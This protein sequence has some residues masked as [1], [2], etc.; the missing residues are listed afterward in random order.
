M[1]TKDSI[2]VPK[3]SVKWIALICVAFAV[4][5][6]VGGSFSIVPKG[7]EQPTAPSAPTQPQAPQQPS[8]VKF[9][10]PSYAPF[11]G[12]SSA[13]I[14]FIENGSATVCRTGSIVEMSVASFNSSDNM[15]GF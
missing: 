15:I 1:P 3:S 7:A 8:I 13:K 2:S 12:S 11:K 6:L 9:D 14:S 4:G 5:Y 10:V